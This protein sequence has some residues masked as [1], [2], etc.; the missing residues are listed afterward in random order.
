[1]RTPPSIVT[2]TTDFGLSGPYVAAMKGILLG[3]VPGVQLVDVTHTI[4]PQNILE[5]AFVLAAIVEAFPPGTV[6]L[7]V[8]DP[9]VGTERRLIAVSLAEHWFVLPDNGLITGV[10]RGRRPAGI[11]EIANGCLARPTIA[12]TFHGRD[13][14]APAAAHLVQGGDPG[15][16]GPVR[17]RFITLRN[18]DANFDTAGLIG[19]V[20]FRDT[21]GNLITNIARAQL[22]E[23]PLKEWIVDVA[24]SRIDGLARTYG[25]QPGGTLVALIGSSG[26]V[27]VAV[28]NGDAAERLSIGPG[29]TIW[30]RRKT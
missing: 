16:L 28:V 21:F 29:A 20:L 8:V 12:P 19:E 18:F 6:H 23:T 9:G 25:E 13:I 10:A 5:G 15:A 2:L 27:E 22:G 30:L 1:M 17:T 4:S 3:M 24:G 7:A 11:W 14:L 26:W